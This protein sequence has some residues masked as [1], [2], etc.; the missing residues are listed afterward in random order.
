MR[1]DLA[2]VPVHDRLDDVARLVVVELHDE[3][4]EIGLD[5]LDAVAF[6]ERAQLHLL[7]G[8][9]LGL[10]HAPGVAA[11]QDREH[12]PAGFVGVDREVNLGAVRLQAGLRAL[13]IDVQV[14]ERVLLDVTGEAAQ[15]IGIGVVAEQR[16]GALVVSGLAA[17]ADGVPARVALRG[18]EGVDGLAA[19]HALASAATCVVSSASRST[20][21]RCSARTG[22]PARSAS[23]A[24]CIRQL[25]SPDTRTSG[26]AAST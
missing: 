25:E 16:L 14:I 8:H 5:R 15:A 4:A 17:D 23:P 9:R 18:G 1:G 2:P 3:L 10:H 19:A 21:A 24:T 7:G 22:R 6:E 12:G 13:E 26:V 11:L 20:C